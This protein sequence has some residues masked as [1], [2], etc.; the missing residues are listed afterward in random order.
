DTVAIPLELA[1][2]A[3]EMAGADP[4]QLPSVFASTYGDLPISDWMC[5]TLAAT[6]ALLSPTKF[7]NSVHNAAAGY[8]TIG[9]G[10]TRASTALCAWHATF[11]AGLLAALVEAAADSTP[12]L[13]V[14]YDVGATGPMATVTESRGLL[15]MAFVLDPAPAT[16]RPALA[17]LSAGLEAGTADGDGPPLPPAWREAVDANA[18]RSGLPLA[19]LLA[20]GRPG[21]LVW[22]VGRGTRL[23][24]EVAPAG[25]EQGP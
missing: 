13:Y 9:T 8:W 18:M 1:A 12:V 2:R 19:A 21:R 15:A 6:P 7:H 24:V 11:G 16:A 17:R 25:R 10:C 4:K 23:R 3:C 5:A 22:D 20:S 14:A